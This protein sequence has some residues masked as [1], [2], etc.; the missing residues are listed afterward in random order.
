MTM[1]RGVASWPGSSSGLLILCWCGLL[2][3]RLAVFNGGG[4]V[5][6]YVVVIAFWLVSLALAAQ[7]VLGMFRGESSRE[8][9][10]ILI[11]LLAFIFP[12][13][14][15]KGTAAEVSFGVFIVAA[16]G[17]ALVYTRRFL[18]SKHHATEH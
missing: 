4:T 17:L 6:V 8:H 16:L 15:G 11:A 5:G 12:Q 18:R 9:P 13:I 10:L 3:I 2:A 7:A 14:S 1:S